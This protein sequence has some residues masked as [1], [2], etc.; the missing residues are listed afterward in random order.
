[1]TLIQDNNETAEAREHS[2]KNWQMMLDGLK[3]VVEEK[4]PA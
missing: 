2:E 3:A 4:P 1:V